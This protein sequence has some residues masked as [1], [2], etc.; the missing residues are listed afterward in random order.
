MTKQAKIWGAFRV[1]VRVVM[2]GSDG[3]GG[4]TDDRLQRAYLDMMVSM[5][6]HPLRNKNHYGSIIVS[7]LA[8]MGMNDYGRW[9]S[10]LSYMPIYSAV[11]NVAKYLVLH[12]SVLERGEE[13]ARLHHT[14][15]RKKAEEKA[16]GLFR[17]VRQKVRRF[18]TRISD[19]ADA[20]PTPMNWIIN[21]RT[22]GLKI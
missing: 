3:I 21:T 22:Y 13:I 4:Y 12:Q 14:T 5:L 6:V 9:I 17:I 20:D 2:S 15:S 19:E 11:I 7:A 18:M 10:A 16:T 8:V 1:A